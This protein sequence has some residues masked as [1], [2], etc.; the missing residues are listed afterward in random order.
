MWGT[1]T[2][3]GEQLRSAR[4]SAGIELEEVEEQTKIRQRFL[5]AMEEDR[6]ELLPGP[7]FERSFL[8]TYADLLGLDAE[9][10]VDEHRRDDESTEPAPEAVR[11]ITSPGRRAPRKLEA[12]RWAAIA[13]IFVVAVLA[14]LLVV[15]LVGGPDDEAGEPGRAAGGSTPKD[16]QRPE[17]QPEPPARATLRLTTTATV[18][19]CLVDGSGEPLVEGVTLQPGEQQGPFRAGLLEL[20]LGNGSVELEANGEPVSIPSAAEP[21]GY[22]VT[23]ER[24]E[25]LAPTERPTCA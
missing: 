1:T 22:R 20:S 21:V 12:G 14:A 16:S 13:G 2:S 3:I 15:G 24:T 7:A 8:R 25:E 9:A 6:W 4:R 11:Q 5:R 18:W 10:L 23:P 19:V 17:R